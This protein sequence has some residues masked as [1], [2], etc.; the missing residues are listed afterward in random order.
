MTEGRASARPE[1][2]EACPSKSHPVSGV[3]FI[4]SRSNRANSGAECLLLGCFVCFVERILFSNEDSRGGR[5][6]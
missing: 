5:G 4:Q 6:N 3:C 1:H 2:P